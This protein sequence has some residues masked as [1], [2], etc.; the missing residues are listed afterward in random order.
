[1]PKAKKTAEAPK[2]VVYYGKCEGRTV[3]H[4][5]SQI[6]PYVDDASTFRVQTFCGNEI[7]QWDQGMYPP[8]EEDESMCKICYRSMAW[9]SLLAKLT[10]QDFNER[11]AAAAANTVRFQTAR[12]LDELI[13]EAEEG[14]FSSGKLIA[15]IR[16]KSEE[17]RGTNLKSFKQHKPKLMVVNAGN[18]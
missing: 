13:Q 18:G 6:I 1:M 17:L 8:L 7:L 15:A 10:N 4:G 9:E 16:A 12:G 14:N 3:Y 5:G 2:V 11:M